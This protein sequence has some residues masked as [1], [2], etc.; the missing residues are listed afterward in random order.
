MAKP[1]FITLSARDDLD[2][3]LLY[4]AKQ[5]NHSVLENFLALYEAKIS[6]IA[7]YPTRYPF[8]NENSFLK[9]QYS[10]NTTLFYT[11]RNLITLKKSAYLIRGRLLKNWTAFRMNKIY[12]D[13]ST[14]MSA[15]WP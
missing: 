14:T 11:E 2:N 12:L 7:E 10:P 8:I 1:V 5:W 3:V 9:R 4:L 15:T 13:F 6:L